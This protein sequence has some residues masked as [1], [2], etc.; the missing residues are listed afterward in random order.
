MNVCDY[1]YKISTHKIGLKTAITPNL[2]HEKGYQV[3]FGKKKHLEENLFPLGK[4]SQTFLSLMQVSDHFHG[5]N[6]GSI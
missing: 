1:T 4:K 6:T 5:E 2:K 3:L